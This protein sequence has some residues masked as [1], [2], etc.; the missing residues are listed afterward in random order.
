MFIA[1]H[2]SFCISTVL[3]LPKWRRLLTGTFQ[4]SV[5]LKSHYTTRRGR[6]TRWDDA[7]G[8]RLSRAKPAVVTSVFICLVTHSQYRCI[9]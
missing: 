6:G 2:I 4:L 5:Q 8:S 1:K 7:S 3:I 9:G